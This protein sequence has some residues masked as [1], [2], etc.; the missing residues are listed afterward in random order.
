L[1]SG[2]ASGGLGAEG[3]R[4]PE[5]TTGLQWRRV[6]PPIIA[7]LLAGVAI[8]AILSS[9]SQ[10]SNGGGSELA[11]VAAREIDNAATTMN[12]AAAKDAIDDAKGCRIPLAEIALAAPSGT[13]ATI[14][15]HSG[16]YVSPPY[17]LTDQPQR[18]AIP[19]PAAYQSGRGVI[20]V[21]GQAQNLAV[22][23][24]PTWNVN[25]LTGTAVK[26]VVWTPKV[27]C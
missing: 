22:S 13:T 25:A 11:S 12:A 19:F 23:L 9:S 21:E 4:K 3:D 1:N 24:F 27:G 26:N 14:R 15:V 2:S 20:S 6:A 8:T 5:N 10:S 16:S 17:V 7:G 18:I